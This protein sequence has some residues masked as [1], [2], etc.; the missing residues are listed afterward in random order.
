M[1]VKVYPSQGSSCMAQGAESKGKNCEKEDLRA[2]SE[3]Q[4]GDHLKKLQVHK[5]MG[6]HEICSRVLHQMS[7]H[8]H[9]PSYLQGDGSFVKFSLI[10]KWEI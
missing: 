5:C 1:I 2:V 10:G 3:D 4:I 8:S 6:P 9:Y 7:L